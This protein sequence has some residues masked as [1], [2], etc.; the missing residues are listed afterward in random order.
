M[1]KLLLSAAL[2]AASFTAFSQVG[3]G[4]T[5]PKATLDISGVASANPAVADGI[6]AP[7]ITRANLIA[8]LL[9]SKFLLVLGF[10]LSCIIIKLYLHSKNKT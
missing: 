4:N 1:K 9:F 10:N 5:D 2:F 8:K 3:I 7:R 6:I